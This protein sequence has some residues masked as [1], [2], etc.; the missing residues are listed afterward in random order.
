MGVKTIVDLRGEGISEAVEQKMVKNNGM[1]FLSLPLNGHLAPTPDQIAKALEI[2]NDPAKWPVFVH[3]RRGA[4][5]TGTIMACY[6]IAHDHWD[7]QKALEEAKSFDM[8][9]G[10]KL[11]QKFIL[12]FQVSTPALTQ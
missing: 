12:Q 11:M 1:N 7:N 4:D 3:C 9:P 10:Q 2:L 5:R 6:R 8:D